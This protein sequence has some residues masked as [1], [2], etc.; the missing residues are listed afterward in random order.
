MKLLEVYPNCPKLSKGIVDVIS[1]RILRMIAQWAGSIPYLLSRI[2]V[3]FGWK[4]EVDI[5]HLF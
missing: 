1:N 2:E 3:R 5:A 4:S